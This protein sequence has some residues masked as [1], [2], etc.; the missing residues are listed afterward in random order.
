[1]S[2]LLDEFEWLK[3]HPEFEERP[4]TFE[5]FLGPNYLN[6]EGKL[7]PRILQEMK[8]MFGDEVD[9]ER[10]SKYSEGLVTGG[11]G[12]GKTTIAS[13]VLPYMC[14]WVLCLKDPQAFFG[15]L[16]GSRIA[17]MMMSTSESQALEV[18]FG[19]V[20]ARI[21]YSPWFRTRFEHD[22]KFKNQ[23]RFPKD[24]WIV[25]GDS[26]ETTFEGYNILG[27]IMDEGDS[28]MVTKNKD[29]AEQGYTTISSRITSRFQDRGFL[30][31]IGQ[32]KRANGFM[33]RKYAEFLNRPD[34]YAVRLSIWESMGKDFYRDKETGEPGKIFTYDTLRKVIMPSGVAEIMGRP[35]NLIEVPDLYRR[36]F[37]QN[38]EKA[39]RDLAGIPPKTGN[40]FISLVDRIM[41]CRDRWV[42]E[43]GPESPV[44]QDGTFQPW[45]RAQDSLKRVAHIDL[46]YS[47]EGDALGMAMGHVRELVKIEGELKPVI[48]IDWMMRM[49]ASA[50]SEIFLSDVRRIIYSLRDDYGFK[51]EKITMD[52]FQST[53]SLQ[54]FRRKRFETE[55][56][57]I[58]KQMLPYSDLRDAIYERRILFPRYI[59]NL[60][61]N[62]LSEDC[63]IA[64]QELSELVDNG[65]KVDHPEQGSKDV[66]DALAGVV[67]TLM[68]DR[69]YRRKVINLSQPT[70]SRTY[71]DGAGRA[72]GHPAFIGDRG[73]HA[74]LA[75]PWR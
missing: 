32:M 40:P 4:A 60:H 20:K 51:L 17:F 27:G 65:N 25:P 36:Q 44:R 29:Y 43:Y 14:H 49:Q 54:Q 23:I 15:L 52:G 5:E 37:E 31:V 42:D 38:P 24:I 16:P 28:H 30:L 74:P 58:D 55:L 1:M 59:V 64:V 10:I 6:I 18:V 50:G 63:E 67:F 48:V 68:G 33:A 73:V 47:G 57:S 21:N 8:A 62:D 75:P 19:D 35:S 22:Q 41:D 26:R 13:V 61:R 46:A 53:D 7:R 66:A 45:F 2:T 72:G 69:R 3:D 70:S 71:G 34:C 9:G 56:V 12:I 39:L 11:I